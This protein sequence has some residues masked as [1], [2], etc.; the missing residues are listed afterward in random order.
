MLTRKRQGWAYLFILPFFAVFLTFSIYPIFYSLYLSFTEYDPLFLTTKLVGM[1]NYTR[2]I[3][4]AYFWE[5]VGNTIVIWLFSI[6]PQLIIAITLALILNE[7]WIKG[8]STLRS[9]YYFP[10]L[11]T[12]VT[13]G[14]LFNMMFSYPGGAI[15]NL[16]TATGLASQAVNFK[17]TPI[18]AKMVGGIAICWQNFGYNI[19][20]IS[21]GL[22]AISQDVY[23]AAEVDGANALRRTTRI[24]LPLLKPILLY[25]MVTSII[26]GLQIFDVPRMLFK[27]G[28]G[29][30]TR[31][32][33]YYMFE[34][35]FE[36][37]QFGYG[38]AISYGIF[39]I[40]GVFSLF[41]MFVTSRGSHKEEK[42]A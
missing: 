37:W 23:E 9:I 29:N 15:N 18:L 27:D 12:P 20:F 16:L 41:S 33:V 34:T 14:L 32:M 4:S 28:M 8:R 19:I 42:N 17:D 3:S 30:A 35:A 39:I 31:T 38:A 11:V 13:I 7:R 25:V 10:N 24:T 5:S 1:Q 2:L 40:I 22:N 6:I 36:R 26:G 21:A